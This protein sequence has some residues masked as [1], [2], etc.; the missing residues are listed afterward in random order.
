MNIGANIRRLRIEKELTQDKLAGMIGI[1]PQAVSKW[2]REEGL[3]DITLLP[4]IAAALDCSTDELLG[5]GE[6]LTEVQI[7]DIIKNAMR[8][9][10]AEDGTLTPDVGVEYLRSEIEKYPREFILRFHLATYLGVSMELGGYDEEKLRERIEQYEYMRM[11]AP[12]INTRLMG[13]MGLMGTYSE[14]GD[15]EKA[16]QMASELPMSGLSRSEMAVQYLRGDELREALRAEIVAAVLNIRANVDMLTGGLRTGRNAFDTTHVGSLEER[17]E[18]VELGVKAWELLK[19]FEW[20]A[21]WRA[22]AGA[23]LFR[24]AAILAEEEQMERALDY[25]ERAVEY[26]RP[27]P[28]EKTGYFAL[29]EGTSYGGNADNMMPSREAQRNLMVLIEQ[30]ENYPEDPI[31]ALTGHPRWKALKDKLNEM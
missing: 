1:T 24:G 16:K 15:F 17:L 26:G 19:G 12:D 28:D 25:I 14:L 5:I 4:A 6:K 10:H 31:H 30:A 23:M 3:P 22:Y 11:K 13:V 18:L 7:N 9:I 27:E 8:L 21:I 20:G 29:R 2:E